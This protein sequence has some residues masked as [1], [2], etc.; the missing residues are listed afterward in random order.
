[1]P[2]QKAPQTANRDPQLAGLDR[3]VG[4]WTTEATHPALPGVVVRGTMSAEWF[5]GGRFL[6]QRAF[7]DRPDFPDA[8]SILGFTDQD[9][10]A[11]PDAAPPVERQRQLTAHA[12]D[13]RG[14]FRVLE[15]TLADDAW[16]MSRNAP[17]FSQRY[18]GTFTD[19][20]DT[21]VGLWQLCRDGVHWNNDLRITYRRTR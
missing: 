18:A 2:T 13:S 16:L 4:E 5:Q 8:I 6:I 10:A 3:L 7:T 19:G 20:G 11:A 12:Y 14:V 21:I 1:M 15:V 17:G 9:R